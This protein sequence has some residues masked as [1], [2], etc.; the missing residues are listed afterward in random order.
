MESLLCIRFLLQ[1]IMGER[2]EGWIDATCKKVYVLWVFQSKI[3]TTRFVAIFLAL[4]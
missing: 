4:E 3:V 1:Q 2:G